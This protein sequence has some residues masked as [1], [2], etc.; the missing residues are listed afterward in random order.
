MSTNWTAELVSRELIELDREVRRREAYRAC[1]NLMCN[2]Q[3]KRSA[4]HVEDICAMFAL[5]T[6]GVSLEVS[7][8]IYNGAESVKRYFLGYVKAVDANIIEKS[9]LNTQHVVN[10]CIE[11]ASDGLTA[12]GKWNTLGG[13]TGVDENGGG[14]ALWSMRVYKIDFVIESGE[15]KFLRFREYDQFKTPYGGK[16]WDE[17]AWYDYTENIKKYWNVDPSDP[18]FA[19]D[20]TLPN[21]PFAGIG[22]GNA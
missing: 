11:V 7:G 15:W 16:G 2:Y 18:K 9:R 19:P 14:I 22:K 3:W 17:C 12:V 20:E 21:R 13:E 5:D 10:P 4:A 8:K 1:S 6:Q